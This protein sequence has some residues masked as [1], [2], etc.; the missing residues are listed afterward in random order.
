MWT[1][2]DDT[3]ER[4]ESRRSRHLLRNDRFGEDRKERKTNYDQDAPRPKVGD[5]LLGEALRNHK[6]AHTSIAQI[7]DD[8]HGFVCSQAR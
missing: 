5:I 8:A 2:L 6:R 3:L 4:A 1:E 7:E